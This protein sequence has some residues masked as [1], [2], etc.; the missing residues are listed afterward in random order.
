MIPKYEKSEGAKRSSGAGTIYF[1]I[2]TRKN[3]A[4]RYSPKIW[5][6][7]EGALK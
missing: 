4:V 6:M 7:F 3:N 2:S 5:K 1:D